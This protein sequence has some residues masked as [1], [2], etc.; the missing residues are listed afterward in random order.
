M[1]LSGSLPQINL[2]VQVTL[3]LATSQLDENNSGHEFATIAPRIPRGKY[4]YINKGSDTRVDRLDKV[5]LQVET[6]VP[7]VHGMMDTLGEEPPMF[8]VESSMAA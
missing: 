3:E 2:G 4:M 7:A 5:T 8:V 1:A 6:S